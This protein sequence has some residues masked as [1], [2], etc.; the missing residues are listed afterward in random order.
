MKALS[1][2][3]PHAWAISH[4]HKTVENRSTNT[5][6][7]GEFLIHASKGGTK[8]EYAEWVKYYAER[9]VTVPGFDDVERGGIVG[10]AEIYE[11]ELTLETLEWSWAFQHIK[12]WGIPGSAFWMLS[13]A[14]PLEFVPLRGQLGFWTVP[15]D[16]LEKV[17]L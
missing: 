2:R 16:V 1:I 13:D 8:K 15:D 5:S 9:G 14:R 3:Q 4:G 6:H 11:V 10:G 17:K 7:R 12:K